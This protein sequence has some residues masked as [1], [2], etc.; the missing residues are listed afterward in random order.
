M[1][2]VLKRLYEIES[3]AEA[4]IEKTDDQGN[5]GEKSRVR[6]EDPGRDGADHCPSERRIDPTDPK[7]AGRTARG[8]EASSDCHRTGLP[9]E[10]YEA[11]K[12]DSTVFDSVA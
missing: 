10:P 9:K 5:G 4:I 1:E 6:P 7:G 12:T 2:Q 3:A 11:G 8:N